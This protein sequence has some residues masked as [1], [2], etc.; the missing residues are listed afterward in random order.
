LNLI[1]FQRQPPYDACNGNENEATGGD[2]FQLT[3]KDEP[4]FL[5]GIFHRFQFVADNLKSSQKLQN[6]AQHDDVSQNVIFLWTFSCPFAR[7]IAWNFAQ[8]N[9]EDKRLSTGQAEKYELWN[10]TEC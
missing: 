4:V 7:S 2:R 3:S 6:N 5:G 1:D 10:E 9:I 8:T